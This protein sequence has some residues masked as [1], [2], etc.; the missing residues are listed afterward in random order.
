MIRSCYKSKLISCAR[1]EDKKAIPSLLLHLYY[2]QLTS[3]VAESL[4]STSS[5]H[6][7]VL[8]NL[9]R[10]CLFVQGTRSLLVLFVLYLLLN[11]II[12]RAYTS[13]AINVH[14]SKK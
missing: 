7:M 3:T 6:F 1:R 14:V 12:I 10:A 9:I 4:R 11:N 13:I 2:I 8:W 5:N